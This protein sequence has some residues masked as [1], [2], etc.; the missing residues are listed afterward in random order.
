[1]TPEQIEQQMRREMPGWSDS[2][3]AELAELHIEVQRQKAEGRDVI[4][5]ERKS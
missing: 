1:M 4:R 2:A 3:Y 5:V